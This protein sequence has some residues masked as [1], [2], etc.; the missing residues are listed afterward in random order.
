MPAD[1]PPPSRARRA[2]LVLALLL[3]LMS[4]IQSDHRAK[5][6]RNALL[7]W[8]P[9]QDAVDRGDQIY[10]VGAEGYPT[11]PVTL[12][13]MRPFHLAG[14]RLGPLLWAACKLGLAWW[15]V[16]TALGLAFGSARHAPPWALWLV[17]LGS[18]RVLHSDVQHGN[19]NLV[20]GAVVMAGI[21]E[22]ARG[23]SFW[24]G[25]AFGLGATLK[26]T[27][28]L[29]LAWLA[30]RR[31]GRGILGFATGLA[32]GIIAP[33]GWLGAGRSLS[34]ARAWVDQMLV[35][36]L[37]GRELT[38]L[39]TEHINQSLLGVLSRH[40]TGAV[41][42][43][44]RPRGPVE[45]L[46]IGWLDLDPS[47]FQLVHVG[48]CLA[49][50][51][52]FLAVAHRTRLAGPVKTLGMGALLGLAMVLLSERSWKHHHVLLPLAVVFLC[53][54]ATQLPTR[55]LAWGL[56]LAAGIAF[57][58]TG[59][60]F[61]GAWGSD[62]AEAYGAYALGDVVLFLGLARLLTHPGLSP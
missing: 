6:G 12:V 57:A 51:T 55:R 40:L 10:G 48:A 37:S 21:V 7:K 23:R 53:Q 43:P 31:S 58:G 46:R 29:G 45:P 1:T 24:A 59:D 4:L 33:M 13:V 22:L 27:P 5:K 42:I 20:V 26:V 34:M 35:P 39:Q 8:A 18:F 44:A 54:A 25:L 9:T 41:A 60:L 61:L 56:L 19:L 32:A 15:M 3:T 36:Y 47:T 16:L 11:L 28:A 2:A 17:L 30:A 49:V 50:L 62:L 52:L 38:L 14:P